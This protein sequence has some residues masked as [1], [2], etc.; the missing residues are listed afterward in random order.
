MEVPVAK[1]RRKG[2]DED[3]DDEAAIAAKPLPP[4]LREEDAGE[5]SARPN[6]GYFGCCK[7]GVGKAEAEEVSEG[8]DADEYVYAASARRGVHGRENASKIAARQKLEKVESCK[9]LKAEMLPRTREARA[10]E[11]QKWLR[12]PSEDEWDR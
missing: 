12:N 1:R 11:G 4:A 5:I 10:G 6:P 2:R 7:S 3:E 9:L 8:N